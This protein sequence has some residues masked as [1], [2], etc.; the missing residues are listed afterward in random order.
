LAP[1][2]RSYISDLCG[3]GLSFSAGP[4]GDASGACPAPRTSRTD[5]QD[6]EAADDTF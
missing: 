5:S 3:R 1:L 6:K 4:W 2:E